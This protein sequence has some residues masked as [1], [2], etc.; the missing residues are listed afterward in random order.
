MVEAYVDDLL[1]ALIA[2]SGIGETAFGG[3]LLAET[4][5]G[6]HNSWKNR[7]G[8]LDRGF[9]ISITGSKERQ[10]FDVM[11]EL[12]NAL[13][14]GD[15]SLSARQRANLLS[16]VTLESK[17]ETT[18]CVQA[19]GGGLRLTSDSATAAILICRRFVLCLDRATCSARPGLN[20]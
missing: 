18:L 2:E 13:A 8:W 6:F 7:Y 11:V 15:G 4:R 9:G 20:Y 12:R 17:L 5:D 10:E 1:R 19:R 16:M 3:A 14:H